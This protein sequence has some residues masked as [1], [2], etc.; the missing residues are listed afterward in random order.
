MS[1][2]RRHP[3]LH[4]V[5][6]LV[7]ELNGSLDIGA[8]SLAKDFIRQL[9]EHEELRAT[10]LQEAVRGIG[11]GSRPRKWRKRIEAAFKRLPR[12]EK[13]LARPAMLDWLVGY[14]RQPWRA[15]IPC[16]VLVALGCVL[17]SPKKMEPQNPRTRPG[18][19][20]ASG[21]APACS[22]PLW[23]SNRIKCRSQ[24]LIRL[25]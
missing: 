7:S 8:T 9:L 4:D 24:K 15:G 6:W 23:T 25:F 10:P 2:S 14:G 13:R 12:T 18:F 20:I 3:A 17:F 19:T 11:M 5:E 22:F 1:K 21:T 16:A